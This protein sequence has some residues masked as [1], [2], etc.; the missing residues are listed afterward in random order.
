MK[1]KAV[2]FNPDNELFGVLTLPENDLPSRKDAVLLLNA[3]MLH[4]V[5]F[6][7][8]NTDIAR[9]LADKGYPSLRFDLHGLGDSAKHNGIKSFDEQAICDIK[10][11][12]TTLLNNCSSK[13]CILIGLCSGADFAHIVAISDKRVSG[14]VFIDGYAYPTMKFYFHDYFPGILNPLKILKF[15]KKRVSGLLNIQNPASGAVYQ[16]T[17]IYI[18]NFPPKSKVVS[19]IN[20]FIDRNIF[21]C[22]IYSGGIPIYYNY[23][24]QFRDMFKKI[25]FKNRVTY[26]FIKEADHTFTSISAR[27]SLIQFILKWIESKPDNI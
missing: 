3:G 8:F 16:D 10:E 7:R 17:E 9:L 27:N 25:D 2:S 4:R 5:G 23:F 21:L 6:N 18:R 1:E 24:N 12:V 20:Q 11:A 14:V 19:E 26:N 15:I 22:Y 13:K